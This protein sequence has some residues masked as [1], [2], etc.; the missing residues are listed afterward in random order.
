[1]VFWRYPQATAH[2]AARAACAFDWC[3][4]PVTTRAIDDVSWY[5]PGDDVEAAILY[6]DR[7]MKRLEKRVRRDRTTMARLLRRVDGLPDVA[8]DG[9]TARGMR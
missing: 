3:G 5:A 1:M 9:R 2:C 4:F 6:A 8:K 7:R